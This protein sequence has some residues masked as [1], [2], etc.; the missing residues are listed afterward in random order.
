MEIG[1]FLEVI[2]QE[3]SGLQRSNVLGS[4]EKVTPN[5]TSKKTRRVMHHSCMEDLERPSPK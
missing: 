5:V 1:K 2:Y 3:D 4:A